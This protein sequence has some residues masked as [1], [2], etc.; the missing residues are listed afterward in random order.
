MCKV[1]LKGQ[2]RVIVSGRRDASH[3]GG[4]HKFG[5]CNWR[6]NTFTIQIME[7]SWVY[8]LTDVAAGPHVRREY[9]RIYS[10]ELGTRTTFGR[11]HA[12]LVLL[13]CLWR[14]G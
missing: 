4:L 2:S 11:A 10:S 1:R 6:P 5:G 13:L 9:E 12:R 14:R 8:A 7:I 3:E